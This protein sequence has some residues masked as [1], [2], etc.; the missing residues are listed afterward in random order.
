[1]TIRNPLCYFPK[2]VH[3]LD[4]Y[5]VQ[6]DTLTV[7]NEVRDVRLHI[8]NYSGPLPDSPIIERTFVS[9]NQM[10]LSTMVYG[11]TA[12]AA[13]AAGDAP[14]TTTNVFRDATMQLI[15]DKPELDF[16]FILPVSKVAIQIQQL[17]IEL[18]AMQLKLLA[19]VLSHNICW[20]ASEGGASEG[21]KNNTQIDADAVFVPARPWTR[22]HVVSSVHVALNFVRIK[23][24]QL[25]AVERV[26]AVQQ[27]LIRQPLVG[28][29]L[30]NFDIFIDSMASPCMD[31]NFSLD[32]LDI[33]DLRAVQPCEQA[34]SS[35]STQGD[36]PASVATYFP[37]LVTTHF[38]EGSRR[39]PLFKRGTQVFAMKYNM[40]FDQA[41]EMKIAIDNTCINVVAETWFPALADVLPILTTELLDAILLVQ[42]KKLELLRY[43]EV[44]GVQV[45]YSMRKQA[46]ISITNAD[47]RMIANC[48]E[49]DSMALILG[50]RI[51]IEYASDQQQGRLEEQVA[52][53]LIDV[54]L[55]RASMDSVLDTTPILEP[56]FL[57]VLCS[58]AKT[59]STIS[60][61]LDH[62]VH[63]TISYHDIQAMIGIANSWSTPVKAY[64]LQLAKD[65]KVIVASQPTPEVAVLPTAQAIDSVV[66]STTTTTTTTTTT[67]T[68]GAADSQQEQHSNILES[69]DEK[70]LQ[71]FEHLK[72]AS[73]AD[74]RLS[75]AAKEI[76]I[77]FVNDAGSHHRSQPLL[78]VSLERT[79]AVVK[80]WSSTLS[81]AIS[82]SFFVDFFNS[83]IEVCV[84]HDVYTPTV[85]SPQSMYTYNQRVLTL[86]MHC[87]PGSR[88]ASHGTS[89]PASTRASSKSGVSKATARIR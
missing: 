50:G 80:N 54:A 46:S 74:E 23:W 87:R 70:T 66:Q 86:L 51:D 28:V 6:F 37:L 85:Y 26:D 52:V 30:R 24:F 67:A 89:R 44:G 3:S 25:V 72:L 34:I 2:S 53:D 78:L 4:C 83:R 35:E 10:Q 48:R 63:A 1:V 82:T 77:S 71:E 27:P 73:P 75:F 12:A 19:A 39:V 88:F 29:E 62:V 81:A 38:L 43:G 33:V 76:W 13:A 21:Y 20:S 60:I 55:S 56:T 14:P 7:T 32:S 15:I 49:R 16:D 65:Q 22:D 79:L 69:V 36:A 18:D 84:G 41:E 17:D 59:D 5:A 57:K 45:Q 40:L 61:A 9:F 47:I 42:A 31:G 58:L 68:T 64:L 8:A 11:D